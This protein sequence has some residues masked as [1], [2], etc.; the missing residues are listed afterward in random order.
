MPAAWTGMGREDRLHQLIDLIYEAAIEPA[1]WNEV[2]AAMSELYDGAA[3]LIGIGLPSDGRIDR[4]YSCGIVPEYR[5]GYTEHLVKEYELFRTFTDGSL[6]VYTGHL[7]VT[8]EPP[9][10]EDVLDDTGYL[11]RVESFGLLSGCM[12]EPTFA[13]IDHVREVCVLP[14]FIA[15]RRESALEELL[16]CQLPRLG[17]TVAA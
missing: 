6:A 8:T 13:D 17:G 5:A 9:P 16:H 11:R 3:V 7:Y 1:V 10:G 2:V 14:V 12:R 4:H 15:R